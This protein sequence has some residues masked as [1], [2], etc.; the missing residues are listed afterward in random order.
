[1]LRA[2][3]DSCS[4]RSAVWPAGLRDWVRFSSAGYNRCPVQVK[5]PSVGALLLGLIPVIA[6]CLS[7]SLWDRIDPMIFGLP[8]NLFWL[9][10]W[11]VLSTLCMG[12]AYRVEIARH[13]KDPGAQ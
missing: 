3:E 7:V 12:A 10:A 6:M 8:F 1:M 5:K 13:K 9:I 2:M 11:I 4:G